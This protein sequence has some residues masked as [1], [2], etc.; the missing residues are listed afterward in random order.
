MLEQLIGRHVEITVA[1]ASGLSNM[2]GVAPMPVCYTGT[3]EAVDEEFCVVSLRYRRLSCLSAD[4]SG[5]HYADP[6]ATCSGDIYIRKD[7]ILTC[8][9]LPSQ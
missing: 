2:R 6:G 7:S 5:V 1:L 3:L 8:H 4:I 9:E